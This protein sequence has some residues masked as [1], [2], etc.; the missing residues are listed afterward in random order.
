MY[1]NWKVK[2]QSASK[3]EN[4]S[5]ANL[6]GSNGKVQRR[7]EAHSL[8]L[9]RLNCCTPS[10]DCAP[11]E[12]TTDG[13]LSPSLGLGACQSTDSTR[14]GERARQQAAMHN[15]FVGFAHRSPRPHSGVQKL[16]L[17]H[18]STVG[19]SSIM[20]WV[21]RDQLPIT[22]NEL[23]RIVTAVTR[24]RSAHRKKVGHPLPILINVILYLNSRWHNSLDESIISRMLTYQQSGVTT[25]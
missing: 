11:D 24:S 4:I 18:R 1:C 10:A 22:C 19:Y 20:V 13:P 12:I 23:L 25:S 15:D 21:P 6:V 2:I 5:H 9:S 16:Q 3:G 8:S 14:E 17:E 7:E